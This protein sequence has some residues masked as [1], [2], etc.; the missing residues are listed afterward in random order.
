MPTTPIMAHAVTDEI[1]GREAEVS[2][3][4]A[5]L[6]QPPEGLRALVLEGEAGIG[7]S[8]I[9][10]AAVAAA[11]ESGFRV[12]VSRPAE[13]EQSLPNLVLGDL[14]A[15]LPPSVLA[16]LPSPRRR[17]VEAAL[18]M[19]DRPG[20]P[21]DP[22]AL[23]VAIVTLLPILAGGE[24]LVLAIDDDQWMDRSSAATLAFALRRSID[25]HL[26]LLLARRPDAGGGPRLEEAA[27]PGRRE[28]V[29]IGPL[30]VG[31]T[32]LLFRDRL[33]V[34]F[35]RPL[36]V[37]LHEVSGGNP[38]HALELA[39]AQSSDPTRDTSVPVAIATSLSGLI[40]AR[41]QG[42]DEPT[43]RVLLLMAAHGR[44]PVDLLPALD[45]AP[46]AFRPALEAHLAERSTE[47][48]SFT[49]PLLAAAV[50]TGAPVEERR[51]AHRRLAKAFSDPILR[52]R[53]LALGAEGPDAEIAGALDTAAVAARD[54]GIPIAAAELAEHALRLTHHDAVQDRHRR[55]IATARANVEAGDGARAQAIA[56]DL[57]AAAAPGRPR[58]EAL[59]LSAEIAAAKDES[60]TLLGQALVEAADVPA[61]EAVIHAG[62][63][64]SGRGTRELAWAERHAEAS[65]RLADA[66]D[67]DA[68]RARAL[69]ILAPIRF[70]RGDPGSLELAERAY[71]LA[72]RLGD[73]QE[74]KWAGW[75]VG[76][77]LTWSVLTDRAREWLERQMLRW[78]DR[79]ENVRWTCLGYLALVELWSG[80]WLAAAA[81][82]EE[83]R[84]VSI[85]YGPE[86]H[87]ALMF[88][89]LYRGDLDE[90]RRHARSGLAQLLG[91]L[92]PA[93]P[94]GL[95]ICELWSGR[96]ADSIPYFVEAERMSDVR[97]LDEA[98]NRWWRSEYAE[99]LV[100]AGHVDE[101]TTF[102]DAWSTARAALGRE[103]FDAQLM[104]CRGLV[105]AE[106]GDLSAA[107]GLLTTS[108]ER[109]EHAGDPFGR[110]RA[111]HALGVV[112]RRDRQ[113]R[114]ARAALESA[115]AGFEELGAASWA[116]TTRTELARIGGR[117]RIEG[118]SPSEL[119]VATLV[120][121]GRTNREIASA[122]SL[123][124]RTVAGHLTHIYSKLGLR[125]RTELAAQKHGS[126]VRTS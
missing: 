40:D 100:Q 125:S 110:A 71:T 102:I 113:K 106:R 59:I 48:I 104:R 117:Q 96:P 19:R 93:Y 95:G 22:R 74:M 90:A 7:K 57:R 83:S 92:I 3:V 65:L 118:L 49:H 46:E 109:H 103:R 23:G 42:L 64:E 58:A 79:D 61:L 39:R 24:P 9:W 114:S 75:S 73:W 115:L 14:L 21:V 119:A 29:R 108:A 62:L 8:T 55:A 12:L 54:R 35:P 13:S 15:D 69:A 41:L 37:R 60:V 52:S 105:A 44:L 85:Q 67:D 34:S 63:A 17:A 33:D 89:T 18:L 84:A 31:A 38:F 80:R 123:G 116:A 32:Q 86:E 51:A 25:E 47:V 36:L 98:N 78:G 91:E 99:A 72:E 66:L 20:P 112:R 94:A 56:A 87:F 28:R 70:D 81:Y 97:G 111:L 16:A 6:D 124:E 45:L 11:R 77:M 26:L 121:E 126:K 1:V 10:L 120:S 107:A 53:H 27:R 50:Y 101:A 30:T 68:L 43:R 5:F 4:H 122:L 82:A 76:H 2:V 88:T